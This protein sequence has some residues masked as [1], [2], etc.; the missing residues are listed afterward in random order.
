ML[1]DAISDTKDMSL[2]RL[3]LGI[4]LAL[5]LVGSLNLVGSLFAPS[6]LISLAGQNQTNEGQP[7]RGMASTSDAKMAMLPYNFEY[8][9]GAELSDEAVSGSRDHSPLKASV[10]RCGTS[11]LPTDAEDRGYEPVLCFSSPIQDA[12]PLR[13]PGFRTCVQREATT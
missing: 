3:A 13:F 7:A 1:Q 5:T 10:L 6:P 4:A 8:V 9:A 12:W 11:E 2:K